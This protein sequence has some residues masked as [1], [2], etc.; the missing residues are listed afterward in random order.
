M[1]F[2]VVYHEVCIF[3]TASNNMKKSSSL[4]SFWTSEVGHISS[5]ALTV[6][7]LWFDSEKISFD[8]L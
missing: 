7:I 5:S 4:K 2:I 1:C 6:I 3:R 8:S